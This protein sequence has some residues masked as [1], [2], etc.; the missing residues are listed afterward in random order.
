[1]TCSNYSPGRCYGSA[2]TLLREFIT[3]RRSLVAVVAAGGR[4]W[5]GSRAGQRTR[6]P[7][8]IKQHPALVW[9][10]S[11]ARRG[12]L[13][14]THF[15]NNLC[16]STSNTTHSLQSVWFVGTLPEYNTSWTGTFPNITVTLWFWFLRRVSRGVDSGFVDGNNVRKTM[17]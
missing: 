16:M 7:R 1:M 15:T 14:P 13:C 5:P 12:F 2:T 17:I 6:A 4:G 3:R 11:F 9:A 10:A 8:Q